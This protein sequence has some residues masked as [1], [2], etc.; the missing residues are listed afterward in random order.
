M[1]ESS[2]DYAAKH[3]LEFKERGNALFKE[4][5]FAAAVARYGTRPHGPRARRPPPG[6]G[7][8]RARLPMRAL[9]VA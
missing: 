7:R 1:A 5:K 3:A 2:E 4:G 6:G 9:D 8:R